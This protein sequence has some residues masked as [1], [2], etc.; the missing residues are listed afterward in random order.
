MPEKQ[1]WYSRNAARN[2]CKISSV[3]VNDI[4][5]FICIIVGENLPNGDHFDS[6][7]KGEEWGFKAHQGKKMIANAIH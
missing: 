1:L 5:Q 6:L 7:N 2:K 4:R 3:V